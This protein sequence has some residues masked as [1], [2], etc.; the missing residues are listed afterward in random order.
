MY[1]DWGFEWEDAVAM[2]DCSLGPRPRTSM[3]DTFG[4]L[5][6]GADGYVLDIGGRDAAQALELARRFGCRVLSVDPV[7]A[8]I[9]WGAEDIANHEFGHLVENKLGTINHISAPNDTFDAIFSRVEYVESYVIEEMITEMLAANPEL[10]EELAERKAAD[11][12]FAADPWAIRYW[13]YAKTPYYDS[14]VNIYPIGSL[15]SREVVDGLPLE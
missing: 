2:T 4:A 15:D 8:N 9:D 3:Y 10:G 11:P 12:E 1:G 6:I 13:F 7:Q 5:G 14:R